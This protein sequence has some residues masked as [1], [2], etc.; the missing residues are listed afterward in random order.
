MHKSLEIP[1]ACLSLLP[2]CLR[3]SCVLDSTAVHTDPEK[4]SRFFQWVVEGAL[5]W[6]GLASKKWPW[7]WFIQRNLPHGK[8]INVSDWNRKSLSLNVISI[9]SSLSPSFVSLVLRHHVAGIIFS[10]I[11]IF[12]PITPSPHP[13]PSRHHYQRQL[14]SSPIFCFSILSHSSI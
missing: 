11:N 7:I 14:N 1:G 10:L 9:G 13:H 12:S 6:Q 4:P 2:W 3:M 5:P 8:V